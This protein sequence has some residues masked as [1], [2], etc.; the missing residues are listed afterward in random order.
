[1]CFFPEIYFQFIFFSEFLIQCVYFP[2]FFTQCVYFPEIL[3][4]GKKHTGKEIQEKNWKNLQEK[5][6][7][8]E[9]QVPPVLLTGFFMWIKKKFFDPDF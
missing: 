3:I 4:S 1:M 2:N 8:V 5:I 6:E 7:V 9:K